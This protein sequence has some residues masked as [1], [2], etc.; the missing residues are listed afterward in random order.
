MSNI[1]KAARIVRDLSEVDGETIGYA[2]AHNIAHALADAG[3]LMPELPEPTSSGWEVGTPLVKEV[4][5]GVGAKVALLPQGVEFQETHITPTEAR[6][7]ALALLTAAQY[8][9]NHDE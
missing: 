3:L 6:D 5:L 1:D 2:H 8:A 7:L 9:G 4:T